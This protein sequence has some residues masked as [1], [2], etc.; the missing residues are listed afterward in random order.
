[1]NTENKIQTTEYKVP[2]ELFGDLLRILL[3]CK[4]PYYI[5]GIKSKT[6]ILLVNVKF[7][8]DNKFHNSVR[9]NVETIINDFGYYMEGLSEAV[10][11]A[12]END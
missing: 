1:M 12:A 4:I 8:K 11:Y 7:D 2:L 6:N 3:K 9:E 10:L 5:T